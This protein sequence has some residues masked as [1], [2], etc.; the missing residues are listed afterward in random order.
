SIASELRKAIV[1]S[2]Y[3]QNQLSELSGVNRAQINRFVNSERTLTLDT[4]EKIAKVLKLE[5]KAKKTKV[6]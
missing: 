6:R 4:A 1:N 2:C 3:S 5:L